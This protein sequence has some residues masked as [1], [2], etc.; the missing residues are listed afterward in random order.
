VGGL[1]TPLGPG[2]YWNSRQA[3]VAGSQAKRAPFSAAL[4]A[5]DEA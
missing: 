3:S 1:G 5:A 4:R 2:S